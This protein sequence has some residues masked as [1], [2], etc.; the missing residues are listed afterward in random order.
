MSAAKKR[1]RT[2]R[3]W[4][5]WA[6]RLRRFVRGHEV[7]L[8]VVAITA[9]ALGSGAMFLWQAMWPR[10][11]QTGDYWLD[12]REISITPPP[13]WITAEQVKTEVIRDASLDG[14]LS[15][16]DDKLVAQ[17][18]RAF[19]FHPWVKKVQ[20]VEKFHPATVEV[21]LEYRRPAAAVLVDGNLWPVDETG[22]LLPKK[23]LP[24]GFVER[25]PRIHGITVQ[26]PGRAGNPWGD[27]RVIAGAVVAA[28]LRAE[29][30]QLGLQAIVPSAEPVYGQR[31]VY[32]YDLVTRTGSRIAWG[33]QEPRANQDTESPA[34]KAARLVKNAR[35][36]GLL[37]TKTTPET[38]GASTEQSPRETL[39]R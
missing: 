35:R 22:V 10:V 18:D 23:D 27:V 17:I 20:G 14:P 16:L 28:A 30:H 36:D 6:D 29:W 1:R 4:K 26:P 33:P 13:A 2:G 15:I 3:L 31:D 9:V 34:Q 5:L 12:P 11:A 8:L 21:R 25:L 7:V 39:R 24:A 32:T 19:A 37:D 38:R